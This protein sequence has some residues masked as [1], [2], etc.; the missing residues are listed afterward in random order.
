MLV[1]HFE[2]LEELLDTEIK[3][4]DHKFD[5]TNLMLKTYYTKQFSKK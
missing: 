1:I 4:V 3:K 5:P 2:W